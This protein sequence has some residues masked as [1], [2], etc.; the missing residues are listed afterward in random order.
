[1]HDC[2][3]FDTAMKGRLTRAQRNPLGLQGARPSSM[4]HYPSL[5]ATGPWPTPSTAHKSHARRRGSGGRRK[6]C[7][8]SGGQVVPSPGDIEAVPCH[9]GDIHAV[10]NSAHITQNS[11][12][13]P[14]FVAR[15]VRSLS[16]ACTSVTI[17]PHK[18]ALRAFLQ[19]LKD[20]VVGRDCQSPLISH[21]ARV[22]TLHLPIES[23]CRSQFA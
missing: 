5:W 7:P 16:S 1:M 12:P 14:P 8:R 6:R 4:A 15:M 3:E 22:D 20:A 10:R 13:A 11:S 23:V 19:P 18:F 17:S 2:A 21:S 9:L